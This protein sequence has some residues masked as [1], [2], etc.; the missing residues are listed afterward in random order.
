VQ[1]DLQASGAAQA[2]EDDESGLR[3][4]S[5]ATI[6][7]RREHGRTIAYDKIVRALIHDKLLAADPS[8]P[9]RAGAGR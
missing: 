1:I 8:A 2:A 4:F 7:R 3:D 5:S 6:A 9:A